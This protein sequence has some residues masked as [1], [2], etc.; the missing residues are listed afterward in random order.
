MKG[1]DLDLSCGS[2]VCSPLSLSPRFI[3]PDRLARYGQ[4]AT[5]L[6]KLQLFISY[7]AIP[8]TGNRRKALSPLAL[9]SLFKTLRAKCQ[10]NRVERSRQRQNNNSGFYLRWRSCSEAAIDTCDQ[11]QPV[12]FVQY[13]THKRRGGGGGRKETEKKKERENRKK[14][15]RERERERERVSMISDRTPKALFPSSSRPNN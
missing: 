1:S 13:S 4:G 12:S 11:P 14:K 6:C 2:C 5:Q 8:N 9:L 7:V 3:S 15:K 10:R